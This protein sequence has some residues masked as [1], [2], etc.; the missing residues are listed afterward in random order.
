MFWSPGFAWFYALKWF[1]AIGVLIATIACEFNDTYAWVYMGLT[2]GVTLLIGLAYGFARPTKAKPW[3]AGT[4]IALLLI[5]IHII[6][7]GLFFWPVTVRL[8]DSTCRNWL[9]AFV[10]ID[11]F[12]LI[13]ML[14]LL[15]RDVR[16]VKKNGAPGS[17][18]YMRMAPDGD[19]SSD[20]A[21]TPGAPSGSSVARRA[22]KGGWAFRGV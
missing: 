21:V 11:L 4:A 10:A 20:G 18:K 17:Q 3:T 5:I 6:V 16:Y 9:Y 14:A 1:A 8:A 13:F 15:A 7:S 22:G 2:L 19:S 12:A